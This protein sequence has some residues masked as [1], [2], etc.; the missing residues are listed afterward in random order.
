MKHKQ[1]LENLIGPLSNQGG[2]GGTPAVLINKNVSANGTYNASSDNADGYKKVVVA[3]EPNLQSKSV[4]IQQ[5]GTT[6]VS[7][8]QGKDGLSGVEITVNVSGGQQTLD[9][10]AYE[11]WNRT[12]TALADSTDPNVPRVTQLTAYAMRDFPELL[13]VDYR[14]I[15]TIGSYNFYVCPKLKEVRLDR[16]T[17]VKTNCFVQCLAVEKILIPACTKIA[18]MPNLQSLHTIDFSSLETIS[19]STFTGGSSSTSRN[20]VLTELNLPALKTAGDSCV[21]YFEGLTKVVFGSSVTSLGSS[22]C[23]YC[24][25]LNTVIFG[26]E[27]AAVPTL[28]SN[29]FAGT[30]IASGHGYIYVPD[31]L[32]NDW[33]AASN[34]S[35]H[36]SKI[37]GLSELPS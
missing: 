37:K 21:Q 30:A 10:F 33:K 20:Q 17:E 8:D 5:N 34:W 22:F 6:T 7:P 1:F 25:A 32:L 31:A 14:Y 13:T 35:T 4:T 36:A 15:T 18:G 24:S 16:L 27:T 26:A 3:V 29:G 2:G 9:D 11:I 28:G 12:V 23:R 19:N